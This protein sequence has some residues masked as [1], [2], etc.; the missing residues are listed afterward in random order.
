MG[1][2]STYTEKRA[3]LLCERLVEELS[4]RQACRLEGMPSRDTVR[5]WLRDK[6]EF[7]ARYAMACECRAEALADEMI[8]IAD[9]SSNDW[10]MGPK[11]PIRNTENIRRAELQIDIRK[12]LIARLAPKK[13]GGHP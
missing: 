4:L 7:R 5:R 3:A 12:W 6:P 9:D 13:Y 10:L 11:G 1:R 2:P 8:E